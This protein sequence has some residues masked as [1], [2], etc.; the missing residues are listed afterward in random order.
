MRILLTSDWHI[1]KTLFSKSLLEEQA[2]FFED[3]FFACLKDVKP[4]LLINA[5]DIFDRPIP[6][7]D[8]LKLL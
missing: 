6:D 1:G 2:K 8:S 4:D 3:T 5:G 7:L